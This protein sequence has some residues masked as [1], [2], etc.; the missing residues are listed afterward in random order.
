MAAGGALR[1]PG[2][3]TAIAAVSVALALG[4]AGCATTPAGSVSGQTSPSVATSPAASSE[5]AKVPEGRIAYMR[6]DADKVERYFT[7]DTD[8]TNEHKLFETQH[9]A[10][11]GWDPTGTVLWTTTE[12]DGFVRFTTMDPDGRNKVVYTPDIATLNLA[13]GFGSADGRYLGLFGWDD[14]DE[15]RLGLW[16]AR[17]DLTDLH[18]VAAAPEGTIAVEP[19]GMSHDGAHIYFLGDLGPNTDNQFHH[20]G[21]VYVV[22]SDGTGLRQLNPS[23]TKTEVTGTGVSVDGR[24]FAFTAWQAGGAAAHGNAMFIVDGADAVARR[25]TDWTVGMWGASWAPGG[26]WVGYS[27][28]GDATGVISVMRPDGSAA[29]SITPSDT[30]VASFGPVWSPDGKHLLI[31]RGDFHK[32]D[33][34]IMDLDGRLVWQVTR[35]PSSYDVYDWAPAAS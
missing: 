18:Q 8:G 17:T 35:Q 6:V 5:V 1:R 9:C 28:D 31:R 13:P 20:A 12:T 26:E 2:A 15:S 24:Q 4:I 27:S 25:V 7:V 23:G 34:W 32:N 16:V 30:S 21:N 29:K 10:C 3:S 11:I 14:S 19:I 33:L 22:A